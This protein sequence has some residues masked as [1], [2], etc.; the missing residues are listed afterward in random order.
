MKNTVLLVCISCVIF[1]CSVKPKGVF[2]EPNTLKA[3]YS[4][5]D[6]WAA[7][8]SKVD[9]ADLVPNKDFQNRQTTANAD[10]F[11]L[12]PT[13]YTGSKKS[14]KSWYPS[15]DDA[16]TN[17]KTDE[18]TIKYQASIFNGAGRVYAPRYRQM[19]LHGFYTNKPEEKREGEKAYKLAYQ[20]VKTAFEY[21]LEHYNQGRPIIIAAHSQGTG[22]AIT[23]MQE[24]FDGK[25]LQNLLIAAY[26][27]GWPVKNDDFKTIQPCQSDDDV[28]C[29]CSWRSFKNGHLPKKQ[30]IGANI[31]STNPLTWTISDE[32]APKSLN[33]GAVLLKFEKVFSNL[34]DAQVHEGILWVN[35]PK[36]PGSFLY[37]NKN[38]HVADLNFYWVNV[39]ENAKQRVE[40]FQK[41]I[42][43]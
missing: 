33:K 2:T 14:Q 37:W 36:F 9:S 28:Q 23:L 15:L 25:V 20:D 43:N 38:Y 42:K 21:Y 6:L 31:I 5:P 3:D 32:Y 8:P 40:A 1:A 27:V 22:H 4:N 17:K 39:R 16:V 35:K 18:T 13:T 30:Q 34:A 24:F 10:V 19:H 41:S 12:H 29:F 26:L 7:L 11:F